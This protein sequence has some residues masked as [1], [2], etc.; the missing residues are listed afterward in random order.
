M[1]DST[2]PTTS[3]GNDVSNLMQVVPPED[4]P[5]QNSPPGDYTDNIAQALEQLE[6]PKQPSTLPPH[7]NR[8]LLN[9]EPITSNGDI[10]P[11]PHHVMLNHMYTR[12]SKHTDTTIFGVT[13]RYK[14]KF[15]TT[16]YYQKT[17]SGST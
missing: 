1:L 13:T 12:P 16:V 4:A 3:D 15:V 9:S 5:P 10:L 7:L 6:G 8:A 14:G 17:T 11:L 2:Q